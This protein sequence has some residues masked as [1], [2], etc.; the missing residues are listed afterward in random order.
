MLNYKDFLWF[1]LS[2]GLN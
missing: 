1:P 2:K